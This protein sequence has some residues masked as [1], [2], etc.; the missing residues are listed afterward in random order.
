MRDMANL[1]GLRDWLLHLAHDPPDDPNHYAV[2]STYQGQNVATIAFATN[3]PTWTPDL[4]RMTV[5]HELLHCH[6]H[7]WREPLDGVQE[8]IGNQVYVP[9]MQATRLNN[10]LLIDNIARAWAET[11]PLPV[12]AKKRKE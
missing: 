9:V 11:L 5:V 7:R 12:K 2:C 6:T 3:W 8:I 10:E 4:L 1:M